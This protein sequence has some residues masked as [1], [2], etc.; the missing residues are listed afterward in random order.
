MLKF[1]KNCYRRLS[2]KLNI[3]AHLTAEN[4][5]LRQQIIVL[6]RTQNRPKL[7]DRDRLF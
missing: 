3:V 5:A 2:R 4:V 1:I 7:K 6:K